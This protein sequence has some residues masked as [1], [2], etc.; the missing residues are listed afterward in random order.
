M[1]YGIL[2]S[3]PMLVCFFWMSTLLLGNRRGD[4]AKRL[5][6]V[7]MGVATMLYFGHCVYF[8][9]I[10]RIYPLADTLYA[11]GTLSV[12]PLYYL[13]IRLLCE[14]R[15]LTIRN[16]HVLIPAVIS[17]TAC[18]V[19]YAMMSDGERE[20]YIGQV[21][22]GDMDA[23]AISP[24]AHIQNLRYKLGGI[25]IAMQIVPFLWLGSRKISRYDREINNY[26]SNNEGKTFSGI[27]TLLYFFVATSLASFFMSIIGRD[28]F[29][30]SAWILLIPSLLFSTLLY[31]LGYVGNV[32]NFT[33]VD[34]ARETARSDSQETTDNGVSNLTENLQKL[35]ETRE[36]YRQ[37]DIRISDIAKL[38]NTNRTYI[39]AALNRD[40]NVSFSVLVNDYR[41]KYAKKLIAESISNGG[42]LTKPDIIEMS[43]FSNEN[44]FYRT[45]KAFTGKT[46]RQWIAE[47]H[48]DK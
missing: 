6:A 21:V 26:Y 23:A 1:V 38:L 32:Q 10:S 7:F 16:L 29:A 28:H 9:K 35:M 5:L 44:S 48:P 34:F 46:P 8:N 17:C 30:D 47:Q 43:G 22:F 24:L 41:I 37:P 4:R 19:I 2:S 31:A 36:L 42:E 33:A 13:Y 39:S 25:V 40:M 15:K 45:F 20:A 11:L 27:R 3:L 12:Y 18:A 14:S